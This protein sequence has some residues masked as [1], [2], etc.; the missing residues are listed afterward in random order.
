MD[1]P[2]IY[3]FIP[4]ENLSQD[5]LTDSPLQKLLNHELLRSW[6]VQP[7]EIRPLMEEIQKTKES[8]IYLS[9]LQKTERINEIKEKAVTEL[10]PES[11]RDLL[12]NRL[13]ETAFVFFQLGEE[14]FARLALVAAHSLNKKDSLFGV[15]PFLKAIVE[16]TLDL[17][18]QGTEEMEGPEGE[19]EDTAPKLI[20]P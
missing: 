2:P 17:Y 16:R 19:E 7:E 9:E 10:Y 4:E 1:R 13:E 5:T 12:K 20:L 15:N 14:E 8:P 11:K 3:D 6:V 18:F